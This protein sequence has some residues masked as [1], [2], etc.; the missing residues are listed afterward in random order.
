VSEI[1]PEEFRRATEVTYLGVVWGTMA[2]LKRMKARDRGLI[3]QV[4]SAL[5]YRSIPLQAPYCGAEHAVQGFT[6]SLRSELLHDKS[7]VELTMVHM[8]ALNTPQ[9]DWALS[10]MPRH[11]QPVPPIFQPEVGARAIVW[12]CKHH[13]RAYFVGWPTWKAVVGE[14]FIPAWIDRY[15]A[16][17]GYDGQQTDEPVS[18]KRPNNLYRPVERLHRTRG[19]FDARAQDHSVEFWLARHRRGLTLAFAGAFAAVLA[20]VGRDRIVDFGRRA[21]EQV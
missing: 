1:A 19:D 11:P 7:R 20:F 12:A 14:K 2:A 8:P 17:R 5:A 18:P 3:I 13:R 6:E 9:F 10:R 21:L 4:S 16:K 15:L